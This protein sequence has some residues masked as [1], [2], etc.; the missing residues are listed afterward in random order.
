M[1]GVNQFERDLISQRTKE[2]LEAPR[3]RRKFGVRK[4]KLDIDQKKALCQLYQQKKLT[5]KVICEMFK[6]LKSALEWQQKFRQFFKVCF[7]KN[8]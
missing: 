3:K 7:S 8:L 1:A 2:R 5:I 4:E 6:I